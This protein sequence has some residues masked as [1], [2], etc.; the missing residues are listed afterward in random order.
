MGLNCNGAC[1]IGK[2]HSTPSNHSF[3]RA[4]RI[5]DLIHS[6]LI[7]PIHPPT[8]SGMKYLLTFIDD[9]T[10]HNTVY[11]LRNKDQTLSKF[12]KYKASVEKRTNREIGKLKTDRGGEYSL[13][14]FINLLKREGIEPE[15]GPAH[16]PE[17]N[18]VAE[19]FNRTL[20]SRLRTQLIQ[21]GLPLSMWGELA[22]YS[23][24]QINCSP[25]K[26]IDN[27]IPQTVLESLTVGH[28]HPFDITR[29]NPFGCLSFAV[30]Q[31]Q[32]SKIG[33]LAQ[34]FI[35]VGLEPHARAARLWDKR[36]G[37]I[38]VTGDVIYKEHIF[39]ALDKEKSPSITNTT[40]APDAPMLGPLSSAMDHVSQTPAGDEPSVTP[41]ASSSTISLP[42]VAPSLISSSKNDTPHKE[43]DDLD[44]PSDGIAPS[45]DIPP[46]RVTD[47]VQTS[48]KGQSSTN[49][50]STPVE[51]SSPDVARRSSR[52]SKAPD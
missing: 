7:G 34:R 33:P 37:R 10:R 21:S 47:P 25:H 20:L 26:A 23:S 24:L 38:F 9:A 30:D 1:A 36:T 50:P 51:I 31:H 16:R 3:H 19:Q 35:F 41:D 28:V 2:L 13:S 27:A 43:V 40:F 45:I 11:L 46:T 29:L 8:V 18:S 42:S 5:L 48:L 14:E 39:P 4:P 49:L 17:A 12:I 15:R 44:E 6:D 32:S 52:L 22:V